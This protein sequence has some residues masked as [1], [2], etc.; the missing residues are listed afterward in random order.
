M[1][2]ECNTTLTSAPRVVR[3]IAGQTVHM[4][5]KDIMHPGTWRMPNNGRA[6]VVNDVT[7]SHWVKTFKVMKRNGIQIYVPEGHTA[8]PG[9]N[10]GWVDDMYVKDGV[11]MARMALVG[12]HA[13]LAG[14]N[15]VSIFSPEKFTDGK[16]RTYEQPI[17]HVALTPTPVI[18]GQGPFV[19][20]SASNGSTNQVPVYTE[21]QKGTR[22]D[23]NVQKLADAVGVD[24][25]GMDETTAMKAVL[26]A[27]AGL[28]DE[29][30]EEDTGADKGAPGGEKKPPIAASIKIKGLET[31][32][33]ELTKALNDKKEN[34]N[35]DTNTEPVGG[36]TLRLAIENREMKIDRLVERG[37][38]TPAVAKSLKAQWA[39][40]ESKTLQLSLEDGGD[41]LFNSTIAAL[42]E[43]D[44]KVLGAV[45]SRGQSVSLSRKVPGGDAEPT[46][47]DIKK[48][49]ERMAKMVS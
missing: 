40:K 39:N 19:S 28:L 44:P 22:M 33:S 17:V 26:T 10:R 14:T 25:K 20:I 37:K 7:M 18:S 46:D 41:D 2:L 43:N 11:L 8:D 6:F 45:T 23:P 29:G 27:V 4:F 5:E 34:K 42:E 31:K 16:G 30:G 38:I 36:M 15:A 3:K 32:V 9:K 1:I 21:D 49:T 12:E 47:E 35:V 13:K 24:I 48:T